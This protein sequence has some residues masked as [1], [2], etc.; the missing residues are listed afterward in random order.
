MSTDLTRRD[1]LQ[2]MAAAGLAFE[3]NGLPV[4]LLA[5]SEEVVP[6]TD[7]P[8]PAAPAAGAAPAAPRFDPRNLKEFIV[9]NDLFFAVQH[10]N[11]PTLDPVAYSLRIEGLVDH[12]VALS[13]ADIKKRPRVEHVIGFEC[14]G[15]NNTRG[16]PLIGN[17]RWTGTP[18]AP[19]LKEAGVKT[20]AGGAG[21]FGGLR[22]PAAGN[23]GH[24]G[25]P[26]RRS[27]QRFARSLPPG[28]G[29]G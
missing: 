4:P 16:N 25:D 11:V 24:A 21:V 28:D 13:L 9:P 6:F 26:P 22:G 17:A 7:L 23:R 29:R 19:I 20:P 10:Y 5:Q 8:A 14:S 18:L 12:P 15:N 27:G 2:R 1:V 3:L